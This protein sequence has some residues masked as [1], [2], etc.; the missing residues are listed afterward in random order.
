MGHP[1]AEV[2]RR[3]LLAAAA[4]RAV[5]TSLVGVLLGIHPAYVGLPTG[6]IGAVATAG[7]AGGAL[8]ARRSRSP[9]R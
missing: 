3:R 1:S 9:P 5:A 2:D 6:E 8:A 7:L 4:L